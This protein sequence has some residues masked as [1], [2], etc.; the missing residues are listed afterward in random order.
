VRPSVWHEFKGKSKTEFSSAD[1]YIP[2]GTDMSGT[3]GELN[4]GVDYQVDERTTV[5]GSLGYQKAFGKDS[6]SYEGMIGIK[7]KF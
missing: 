5:T 3:W 7:V 1:G 6:R 2:F 4:L